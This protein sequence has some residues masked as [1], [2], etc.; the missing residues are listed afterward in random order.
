M[1]G[2]A[3]QRQMSL[4][5]LGHRRPLLTG[6]ARRKTGCCPCGPACGCRAGQACDAA[7]AAFGSRL[8]PVWCVFTSLMREDGEAQ[9][10]LTPIQTPHTHMPRIPEILGFSSQFGVYL[11]EECCQRGRS[12]KGRVAYAMARQSER[13]G[14]P[15]VESSSGNLA[16]GL[17]FWC[18]RLGAP[19]PLCLVD[20]CCEPAMREALAEAG[21]LLEPVPLTDREI[22][23]QAG[24][25]KRVALAENY[26]RQGFY[27]PN[28]YDAGDWVRVHAETTGPEI[29]T[30]PVAFDLVAG[31]VGTG[32]TMSGIAASRPAGRGTASLPSSPRVPRSSTL[33]PD[34]TKSPE[35]G[36]RS[37]LG[38]TGQI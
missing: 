19:R 31:A 8:P 4:R 33:S 21:C 27:W 12:V 29:W 23:E 9:P 22:E 37:R 13:S 38:T 6:T 25:H 30:D 35:R 16:L 5:P 26:S 7:A 34:P 36:T 18:R 10:A 3:R 1:I 15:I 11:K 17:G 2:T 32:A 14:R 20:D 24:V 28:Q